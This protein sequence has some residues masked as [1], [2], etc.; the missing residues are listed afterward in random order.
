L[1]KDANIYDQ[2]SAFKDATEF[3]GKSAEELAKVIE[4]AFKDYGKPN[5]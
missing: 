3:F 5:A 4:K 2:D 1:N